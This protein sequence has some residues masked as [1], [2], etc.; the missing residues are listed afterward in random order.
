MCQKHRPGLLFLSEM[1]NRKPLLQDIQTDLGFDKLFTVEP[2]GQSG[3]LALFFMDD[4]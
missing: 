1:K 3:G 4:F 2:V